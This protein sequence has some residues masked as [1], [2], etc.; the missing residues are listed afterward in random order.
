[1]CEKEKSLK[2]KLEQVDDGKVTGLRGMEREE[3]GEEGAEE[4]DGS[5]AGCYI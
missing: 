2:L 4:R 3:R 1:L 5:I